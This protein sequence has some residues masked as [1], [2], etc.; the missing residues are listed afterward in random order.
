MEF[1]RQEYWSGLPF[2]S[3]GIEPR[4]PALQADSLPSEPPGKSPENHKYGGL[5][6]YLLKNSTFKWNQSISK[7]TLLKVWLQFQFIHGEQS[8]ESFRNSSKLQSLS[9]ADFNSGVWIQN[10]F[11]LYIWKSHNDLKSS[12]QLF[13]RFYKW[14]SMV[15]WS[16]KQIWP[17]SHN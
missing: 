3:P 17:I 2:P 15:P 13:S 1:S 16:L 12:F 8:R 10:S 11:N 5:N 7:F 4:S 9:T 6:V 14:L